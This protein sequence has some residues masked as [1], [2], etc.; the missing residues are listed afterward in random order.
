MH[1]PPNVNET[2][3]LNKLNEMK[4]KCQCACECLLGSYCHR[5]T[6]VAL[7]VCGVRCAVCA[8]FLSQRHNVKRQNKNEQQQRTAHT[9]E[10]ELNWKR[11]PNLVGWIWEEIDALRNNKCHTRGGNNTT[12]IQECLPRSIMFILSPAIWPSQD[13]R[14]RFHA[15]QSTRLYA[16]EMKRTKVE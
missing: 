7:G 12:R 16:V 15:T 13:D 6:A 11:W 9:S 4:L 10:C 1:N 8:V 14:I 2:F 3:D 5:Y